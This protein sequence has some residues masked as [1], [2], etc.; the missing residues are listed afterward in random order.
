[1]WAEYLERLARS[2]ATRDPAQQ[3][4][5]ERVVRQSGPAASWK[6]L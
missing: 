1:L 5:R 2:G 3:P 6:K 4:E